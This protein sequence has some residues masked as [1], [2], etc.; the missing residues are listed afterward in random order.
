[1]DGVRR[2]L[3]FV[4]GGA[5]RPPELS[6]FDLEHHSAHVIG[7]PSAQTLSD[8]V[9]DGASGR[10]LSVVGWPIRVIAFDPVTGQSVTL[11]T[12]DR[13]ERVLG[14]TLTSH[15]YSPGRRE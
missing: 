11:T 2:R 1:L 7:F 13:A 12:F 14:S 5:V 4:S 6:S 3:F 10:L 9:W 8:L 15:S